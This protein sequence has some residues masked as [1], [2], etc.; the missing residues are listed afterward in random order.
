MTA[1]QNTPQTSQPPIRLSGRDRRIIQYLSSQHPHSTQFEI[2]HI[3]EVKPQHEYAV[4]KVLNVDD[5]TQTNY[6]C[7]QKGTPKSIFST[8]DELI[9][10]GSV[11]AHPA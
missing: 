6:I 4:V 8:L 7:L 9:R 5:V 1:S 2:A 10:Q 11:E 3:I